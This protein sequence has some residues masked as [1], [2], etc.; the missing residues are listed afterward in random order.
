MDDERGIMGEPYILRLPFTRKLCDKYFT[1]Q[2][3]WLVPVYC[4][5]ITP[6]A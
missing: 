5:P 3:F 1:W 2:V 6:A 4:L